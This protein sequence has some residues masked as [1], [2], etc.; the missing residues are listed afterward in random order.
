MLAFAY[1]ELISLISRIRNINR[2]GKA[3]VKLAPAAKPST[4]TDALPSLRENTPNPK[5]LTF[6]DALPSLREN[7][8]H[9]KPLTFTDALPSLQDNTPHPKPL[10]FTVA[11][12]LRFVTIPSG[13]LSNRIRIRLDM[14]EHLC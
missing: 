11:L 5:P 7:T 1:R 2:R 14:I 4:F 12:P 6:T 8:P 13:R 9:P 3:S 10:T